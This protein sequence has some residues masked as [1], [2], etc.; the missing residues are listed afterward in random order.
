[1]RWIEQGWYNKSLKVYVLLPFMVVFYVIYKIRLGLFKLGVLAQVRADIPVI[2]VGNISVGGTGKTPFVIYLVK[3]LHS[4]GYTPGIVSRGYGAK[5]DPTMPFPRSVNPQMQVDYSGDEPKLMAL[6]TKVPVVISPVR[7]EAV[8]YLTQ[9]FSCDI[10]ISDDGLQHYQMA[11]DVEIVIVDGQRQFGNGWM[12]PVGPLREPK[13]R[14]NSVDLI[15]EN[16]GFSSNGDY[17]QIAGGIVHITQD[18]TVDIEDFSNGVHLVS[19]I[20]NPQRF[21]QTCKELG[22]NTLS[23]SWFDDHHAFSI[24]D[25]AKFG[26]EDIILMTEKDAVKCREFAQPNWYV[27]PIDAK[28]SDT[29]EQK[30]KHIIVNKCGSVKNDNRNT[31]RK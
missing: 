29:L 1:M 8:A 25:F 13:T 28:I 23:T 9:Q 4:M 3:L 6:R 15:V 21:E 17:Q 5:S 16:S 7:S 31:S 12:L 20:G 10:V 26:S 18:S 22:I 2:V 30:I 24:A 19:G 14:L 11:R 27:L